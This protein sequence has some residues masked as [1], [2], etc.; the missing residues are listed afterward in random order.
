MTT[1]TEHVP[2]PVRNMRR[3]QMIA[4][5]FGL[6]RQDRL[7]I[8]TVLFNR[9]VQSW[10]DLDNGELNTLRWGLEAAVLVCT[11]HMERRDGTRRV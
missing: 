8:A 2:Q 5:A 11:I 6:T 1:S 4:G 10:G 3:A 7:E 9:Q